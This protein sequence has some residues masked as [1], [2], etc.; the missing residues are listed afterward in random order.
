MRRPLFIALAL[1]IAAPQAHAFSP[2]PGAAEDLTAKAATLKIKKQR[3]A[4][5]QLIFD[6][7]TSATP[8]PGKGGVYATKVYKLTAPLKVFRVYTGTDGHARMGQWWS[9]V[10][11]TGIARSKY[12]TDYAI[13]RNWNPEMDT[14]VSCTLSAG[15]VLAFGPGE[16]VA[17]GECRDP[18]EHY[19]RDTAGK[20]PQI[21]LY[22]PFNTQTASI[23]CSADSP[24]PLK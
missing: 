5:E 1:A 6:T 19:A 20:Y 15:T 12:R 23:H 4:E 21:Y 13:C 18:H 14:L 24:H 16:A 3:T 9:H 22:R 11:P 10:N 8:G 7:W 17:A 2:F